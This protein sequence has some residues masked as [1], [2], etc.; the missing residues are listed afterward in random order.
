MSYNQRV[1]LLGENLA[2]RYLMGKG[3]RIVERNFRK[4]SGEIDI[5]AWD[6]R[7]KMLV[8]VEVKTRTNTFFGE[9]AEAVNFFKQ[10]KLLKTAYRYLSKYKREE[11]FRI[12]V[13]GIKLDYIRRVARLEHIR[14]AVEEN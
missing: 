8:F 4:Q 9:P 1:G 6:R 12:D 13:I 10:Q 14:N 11:D 2:C 7:E 3:Y 5:L